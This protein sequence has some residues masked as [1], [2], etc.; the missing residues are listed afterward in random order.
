MR[1]SV[2]SIGVRSSNG[3]VFFVILIRL[4]K[5]SRDQ[6]GPELGATRLL[7]LADADNIVGERAR[8]LAG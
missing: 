3:N 5:S 8:D 2:V 4:A 6:I 1:G 7:H